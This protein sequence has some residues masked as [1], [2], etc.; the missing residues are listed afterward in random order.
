MAARHQAD[1]SAAAVRYLGDA[2]ALASRSRRSRSSWPATGLFLARYTDTDVPWWDAFPTAGSVVGQWLLG[3]KYVENWPA[4]I[5]VN[6]VG[7]AL[8]AYKGL[9]LTVGAVRAVPR[10]GRGRLARMAAARHG[11]ACAARLERM[12]RASSIALARRREHRQDDARARARRSAAAP[13]ATRVGV[14]DE[15]LR[16]FCDRAR[17]H[18]ARDEQ[19]RIAAEQT[20]RIDAAAATHDVVVADTTALMIAVYSDSGVRRPSRCTPARERRTAAAT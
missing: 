12:K 1:G 20:R 15:Y 7:V 10:D 3:R 16:E 11:A 6:V 5:A 19:R 9:W 2:R 17:P 8:F 14:V 18:A 13:T 4:W